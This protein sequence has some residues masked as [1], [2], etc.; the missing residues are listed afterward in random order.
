MQTKKQ[1]QEHKSQYVIILL[2]SV[3][4]V[5]A[6]AGV[7]ESGF[8]NIDDNGYVTQNAQVKSGI[9]WQTVVWSFSTTKHANW[10]P[11][12]WL[13]LALDKSLFGLDARYFHATNLFLH[14]LSSILL[15]LVLERMTRSR[16]Q[17]A[18]VAFVFA[19]H[20]LHVESVAWI[21]ERKD[22]LAGFFWMLTMGAYSFYHQ[23][24]QKKYYYIT[25]IFFMLGLM[26]KPMLVTLPFVLLLLDYWPLN[27]ISLSNVS[28]GREKKQPIIPLKQ[29]LLEKLPFIILAIASSIITFI[30]QRQGEAMNLG[31]ALPFHE[32]LINAIISYAQYIGKTFVPT[33]LAVFYPH[34]G[35][36]FSPGMLA[37]ATILLSLITIVVWK[38]KTQ[39]PFLAFGWLWF[40]GTLIPMLGIVQVGMQ[41][42]ADR[43]MYVPIIGLAV[44]LAWGVPSLMNQWKNHRTILLVTFVFVTLSMMFA[45]RTQV[46]YWKNSKTIL[47]HTLSVTTDNYFA[48]YC[49]GLDF[50]DSG[51]TDEAILHFREALR[52]N[53][54]YP[55]THNNL[56]AAL[57]RKGNF[58]EAIPLFRESIRLMPSHPPTYN[59]FGVTLAQQGKL[60]E[61][62]TQWLRAIELDPEFADAHANLGR[63]FFL[64]E[65]T[66]EAIQHFETAIRLDAN[67]VNAHFNYGN[68]LAKAGKVEE[69]KF[70]YSEALRVAPGFQAA[71]T[72]LRQLGGR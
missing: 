9:S 60:D 33:N 66:E 42:M 63:L 53:P 14:L 4:T 47:E 25:L 48:H 23:S 35:S 70:H 59:N 46:S 19:L 28:T 20:P 34:P 68:V 3:A 71:R 44:M 61:A 58:D 32:R 65:K 5:I 26:A 43:Y 18:F 22:V 55:L 51:K 11:L 62:E 15:F 50:A 13:S 49:L 40:L 6:F 27:R 2:L 45:T 1:Q 72:A 24:S 64:Q 54:S 21:S 41:G 12:T 31:D 30:A 52:I 57:S 38:Q 69:A 37:G 16:W 29:S 10:H 17:S 56:G 36:D 8:T 39:R 7:V 67:H